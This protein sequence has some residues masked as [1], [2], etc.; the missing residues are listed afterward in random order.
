MPAQRHA[1]TPSSIAPAPI[2]AR[3]H[4]CPHQSRYI[5]NANVQSGVLANYGGLFPHRTTVTC[6]GNVFGCQA[7][8]GAGAAEHTP[9]Q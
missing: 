5:G 3:A 6:N 7:T 4:K 9:S 8:A 1:K 2:G